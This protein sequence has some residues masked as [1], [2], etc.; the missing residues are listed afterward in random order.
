M[1]RSFSSW[2]MQT[3]YGRGVTWKWRKLL[4]LLCSRITH[5]H[6][7]S[8]LHYCK[9]VP[10]SHLE[11]WLYL[12]WLFCMDAMLVHPCVKTFSCLACKSIS[13]PLCPCANKCLLTHGGDRVQCAALEN[14]QNNRSPFVMHLMPNISISLSL[15]LSPA[16]TLSV[17]GLMPKLCFFLIY[18]QYPLHCGCIALDGEHHNDII[19]IQPGLGNPSN[20]ETKP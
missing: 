18:L 6:K 17:V 2:K 12:K 3:V 5:L 11:H 13:V 8:G 15:S 19:H 20:A 10:M 16:W 1:F 4:Q 14:H 7:L 9:W